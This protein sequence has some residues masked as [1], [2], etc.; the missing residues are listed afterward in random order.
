MDQELNR[1]RILAAFALQADNPAPCTI[2]VR[3]NEFVELAPDHITLTIPLQEHITIPAH[4][5]DGR[6]WPG[7]KSQEDRNRQQLQEISRQREVLQ[8]QGISAEADNALAL[9]E[10]AISRN[11]IL[12]YL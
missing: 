8:E 6:V 12:R 1:A 10:D 7:T 3:P 2:E 4:M 5:R 9:L 11:A